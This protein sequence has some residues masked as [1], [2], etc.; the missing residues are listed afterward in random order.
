[1]VSVGDPQARWIVTN[2]RNVVALAAASLLASSIGVSRGNAQ[3]Y[4][5]RVIRLIVTYGP[6]SGT[7]LIA[8]VAAEAMA[9]DL[10]QPVVIENRPGADGALG[11]AVVAKSAPDGY[12]LLTGANGPI[13]TGPFI[14]SSLKYDP[15]KDLLPVAMLAYLPFVL[16]VPS[17]S[18]VKTVRDLVDLAKS[19]PGKVTFGSP[20]I[21][22]SGHLAG[23]LFERQAGIQMLQ[24]PYTGAAAV[25]VD[26][27]AGR[28]GCFFGALPSVIG[29][30]RSNQVRPI[31]MAS[32]R[33][34]PLRPDL[35]TIAEAGYPDYDAG[36]WVS[37]MAPAGTPR[38]VVG[39]LAQ[40]AIKAVGSPRM[41]DI[42]AN[43]GAE[44]DPMNPEQLADY[45]TAERT[46]WLA[47]IKDIGLDHP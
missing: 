38:D 41:K 29:A 22:S 17:D 44:P 20:G 31:A 23:A 36:T 45:L 13:V 18:P 30:I 4:P 2:R 26:I 14:Q 19:K 7:D 25:L 43:L 39:R 35:P 16:V 15:A 37:L 21:G 6:G 40:S 12:T 24:V 34:S 9:Q 11:T 10:G 33:R 28:V 5:N 3:A 8:R 42:L 1:M 27:I 47:V 46:R 32:L